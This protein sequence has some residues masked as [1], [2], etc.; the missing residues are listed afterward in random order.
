MT[1]ITILKQTRPFL[2]AAMMIEDRGSRM[3]DVVRLLELSMKRLIH[4]IESFDFDSFVLK[5]IHS[6]DSFD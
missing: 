2:S 5:L 4:S 6:I 1:T 3:E